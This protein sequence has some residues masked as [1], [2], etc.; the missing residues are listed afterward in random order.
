MNDKRS[1]L[2]VI[3]NLRKMYCF[4]VLR[5]ISFT[6]IIMFTDKMC[7]IKYV[8]EIAKE[9]IILKERN[10]TKRRSRSITL[11]VFVL[12]NTSALA[13]PTQQNTHTTGTKLKKKT[14]AH[15]SNNAPQSIFVCFMLRIF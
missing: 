8:N 2:A 10:V 1:V 5:S 15:F 14:H 12:F 11:D 3:V 13:F 4:S 6:E 7:F 9:N